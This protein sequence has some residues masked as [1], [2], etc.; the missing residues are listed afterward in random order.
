MLAVHDKCCEYC[1]KE[2]RRRVHP[3]GAVESPAMFAR[4]RF[5]SLKCAGLGLRKKDLHSRFLAKVTKTGSCWLWIGAVG[6]DLYGNIRV[7]SGRGMVGAHRVSWELHNGEIER[8]KQVLHHCDNRLCVNPGH[9]YLG[10]H[11]DNMHDK[12][13]RGRAAHADRKRCGHRLSQEERRRARELRSSGKS[14]AMIA[15]VLGCSRL[16]AKR[17]A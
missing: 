2:L 10:D 16:T 13:E 6:R 7:G 8:G 12:V 4:R 9:L 3:C 14:I 15:R 1:N 5:C 17:W 11:F